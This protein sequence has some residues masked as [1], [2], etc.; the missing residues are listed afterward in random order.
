MASAQ[1]ADARATRTGE[2]EKIL[3]IV[4]PGE[5]VAQG[6]PRFN[7]HT[8]A[9]VD[10]KKS[11][12]YKKMVAV[13]ARQQKPA[14][15]LDEPLEVLIDIYRTPPKSISNVKKNR[16]ALE[17]ELL[18]PITKPDVDN[19]AKGIKDALNGIIW[20]D[21]SIVVDLRVRKFYSM[22]PRAIVKVRKIDDGSAARDTT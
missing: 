6:R 5:P 8:K 11:R 22:Q 15:L 21:D 1:K 14:Q 19:Y 18:R 12:D 17:K 7:S 10:P 13:Y 20:T 16:Q 9:A 3:E 4:I 2:S